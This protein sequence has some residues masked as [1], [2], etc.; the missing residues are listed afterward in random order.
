MCG[1]VGWYRRDGL[2]VTPE[3]IRSQ[4]NTIVHRGPDDEGILT[5]GDLGM[6]MRRLSIIDVAGGHQPIHT[7]D[8]RHSIVFNGEI[9]NHLQL[10]AELQRTGYRFRTRSDTETILIAYR[11]WGDG[12]WQR[13]EGMFA[14]AI[15]DRL[16]RRLTLA[17]DPIGIKPL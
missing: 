13:L 5:D 15:W 17:R 1:I 10:R 11:E 2:A 14:V 7:E 16:E 6:G 12:A 9:Y 4:C 8:G 3:V